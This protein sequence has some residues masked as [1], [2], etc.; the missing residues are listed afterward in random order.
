MLS[1]QSD[2]PISVRVDCWRTKSDY[3]DPIA[4]TEVR[5]VVCYLNQGDG[6]AVVRNEG[7]HTLQENLEFTRFLHHNQGLTMRCTAHVGPVLGTS[8]HVPRRKGHIRLPWC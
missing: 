4:E 1:E 7:R 8:S 6:A 2:R 3:V 5:G